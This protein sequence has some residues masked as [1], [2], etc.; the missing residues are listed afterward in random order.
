MIEER[1]IASTEGD[2]GEK[3]IFEKALCELR[4]IEYSLNFFIDI[5]ERNT[6]PAH[7][8]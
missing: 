6:K 5:A 1:I 2:S 8:S 7:V 4:N 3:T